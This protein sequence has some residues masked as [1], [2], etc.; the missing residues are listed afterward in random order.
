MLERHPL[1]RSPGSRQ[2]RDQQVRTICQ[3]CSVA[4]GLVA[5]VRE[6]R[7]VD[8]QGDE[9]HPVSRGRLCARGTA[10]VQGITTAERLTLPAMKRKRGDALKPLDDWKGGVDALA[11]RLRDLKERHGP[12]SL[13]IACDA[14]GGLEFHLG[15]LRFARLWGTAQVFLAPGERLDP[16]PEGLDSPTAPCPEWV[17]AKC[18]LLVAADLAATHP[19]AFGWIQE[20]QRRGA[21]VVAVDARFTATLAQADVAL[22]TKPGHGNL[23]GLALAKLM[24][25]ERADAGADAAG[26]RA[27]L[28]QMSLDGAEG[29]L[30]IS[31][32]ELRHL[33]GLLAK[34]GPAT[35]ITGRE[36]AGRPHHRVW[37]A[38]ARAMGWIGRPGGGWYPVDAGTPPLVVEG[39]PG[40]GGL[41]A[42][43]RRPTL[44]EVPQRGAIQAFICSGNAL[45]EYVSPFGPPEQAE[46][47]AHFGAFPNA[48]WERA[49]M[50]FPATLWAERDGLFF[51]GD[52]SVEWGRAIV[53]PPAGCRSGL[54]FWI[55]LARRFGWEKQFP[56]ATEDGRAD[57]AAFY[58]WLLARSPAT[59]GVNLDE[60]RAPDRRARCFW[61]AGGSAQA[62]AL[63]ADLAPGPAPASL[64]TATGA[65]VDPGYPLAV[66]AACSP[67]RSGDASRHWAWTKDLAREDAVQLHPET[68]QRL[69]IENGDEVLVDTP[70]GALSGCASLSRVV[71]RGAVGS[72]QRGV[73]GLPALVRKKDQSADE[74]RA[75]LNESK[76]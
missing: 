75:L 13:A 51:G 49:S 35:V 33:A 30:G 17:H 42:G 55:E 3:E 27:S 12:D 44:A 62:A 10:F 29:M 1:K 20:A 48:T 9:D 53:A 18:L 64:A 56:W 47:V 65:G 15:A 63:R 22:R 73:A 71:S 8:V 31:L 24:L 68:A 26:W 43:G 38:L 41:G 34:H 54:D 59:L 25:S 50:T 6:G 32:D 67:C 40:D 23:L 19:V 52:R 16:S 11:E 7:I 39:E 72:Y 61:P 37:F 2:E 60:V 36:L 45:A 4:C 5:S 57:H 14:E 70:R 58:A 76:P 28:A 46:L 66:V 74:A 69:G 21:Q